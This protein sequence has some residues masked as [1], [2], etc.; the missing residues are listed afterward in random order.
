LTIRG[1]V[2]QATSLRV[3]FHIAELLR[4]KAEGARG[5][6]ELCA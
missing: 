3:T 6:P 5:G 4:L 1:A 2:G